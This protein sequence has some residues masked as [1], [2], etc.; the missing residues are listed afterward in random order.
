MKQLSFLMLLLVSLC[1]L[2]AP[3]TLSG[4]KGWKGGTCTL[5]G[6]ILKGRAATANAGVSSLVPAIP[7]WRTTYRCEVRGSGKLRAS[8]SGR[9]GVVTSIPVFELTGEW[10]PVEVSYANPISKVTFSLFVPAG[11]PETSF[12]VRNFSCK[13]EE[14][15]LL[16]VANVPPV[17]LRAADMPGRHGAIR[18]DGNRQ[19]VW[20]KRWYVAMRLPVPATGTPLYYY[21]RMRHQGKG[22]GIAYLIHHDSLQIVAPEARFAAGEEWQWLRFGPIPAGHAFPEAAIRFGGDAQSQYFLDRVVVTT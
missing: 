16:E 19:V 6:D 18:K 1:G 9:L 10:Q 4:F 11:A 15:L 22:V 20:G 12:E 7:G 21:A 14:P 2:A 5:E 13:L 8:V 3:S 17:C